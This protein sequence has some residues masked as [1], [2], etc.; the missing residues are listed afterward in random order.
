MA[1]YPLVQAIYFPFTAGNGYVAPCVNITNAT[2]PYAQ[3]QFKLGRY[4]YQV[5]GHTNEEM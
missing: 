5:V 3:T 1:S 4:A 2:A